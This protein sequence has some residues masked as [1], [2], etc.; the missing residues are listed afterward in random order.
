MQ[1]SESKLIETGRGQFAV[2]DFGG[3]G[4][5]L[6]FVHGTGHNLE[7]WHP[8]VEC[9]RG[10]FRMAAFDLRGH[11]QTPAESSDPEQYWRDIAEVV[12]ALGLHRPLLI[13]HSTGAYAVSAHAANG[14]ECSGIVVLDGFVL[15]G[16]KTPEEAKDW[17]LPR[18]QL[19][20]LFRYGWVAGP[21]EVERYVQ[22]VCR[23]APGDWLNAGVDLA[24]VDAF[25]RRSFLRHGAKYVRRPTM[26]EIAIVSLPDPVQPIYPSVDLYERIAVPAGFVLASRGLYANREADILNVVGAS[27]NRRFLKL[28]CGHNAHMQKAAEIAGFILEHFQ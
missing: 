9:L 7:V 15:D 6:L 18:E 19:W 10:R 28:E 26:E 23:K 2:R 16:R 4:P 14:G 21:D 25:T 24:V 22:E 5:D 13:G 1:N 11:G 20:E 12:S 27:A 3:D 8:L 17:Y